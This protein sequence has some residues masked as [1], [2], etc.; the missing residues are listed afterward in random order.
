MI[1]TEREK[2]VERCSEEKRFQLLNLFCLPKAWTGS[3]FAMFDEPLPWA[4]RRQIKKPLIDYAFD[5]MRVTRANQAILDQ[6]LATEDQIWAIPQQNFFLATTWRPV[7]KPYGSCFDQWPIYMPKPLNIG[8][9]WCPDHGRGL[10]HL[11]IR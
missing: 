10:L 7:A 8:W 1:F 2:N 4:G 9:R 3:N 6:Y 5:H 11:F